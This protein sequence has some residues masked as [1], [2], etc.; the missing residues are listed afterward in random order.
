MRDLQRLAG[1]AALSD[2]LSVQREA[3]AAT[4]PR[5]QRQAVPALARSHLGYVSLRFGGIPVEADIFAEREV[6]P[7]GQV[8]GRFDGFA[9]EDEAARLARLHSNV[10][11][12][13]R[14][15][16]GKYHVFDT[17][18]PTLSG[19]ADGYAVMPSVAD[20]HQVVRWVNLVPGAPEKSWTR[21]VEQAQGLFR[22]YQV[23]RD[24]TVRSAAEEIFRELTEQGM[25]VGP[26]EVHVV[27][28][29]NPVPGKYNF[30]IDIGDEA[31][32]HGG[33]TGDVPTTLE[34]P[35][36]EPTLTLGPLAFDQRSPL[37]TYATVRH[38]LEHV[39]HATLA[40]EWVGKWRQAMEGRPS[41]EEFKPWLKTQLRR[42][43]IP[44]LDY[45]IVSEET[46]EA[47]GSANTECLGY[48][49]GFTASYHM[50]GADLDDLVLFKSITEIAQE[51]HGANHAVHA[52]VVSTLKGYVDDVMDD[53]HRARFRA[54]AGTKNASVPADAPAKTFYSALAK[55]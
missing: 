48:L 38:E 47:G 22:R 5:V 34:G 1:N 16:G 42:G 27:R 30:D 39:K 46:S 19:L 23:T 43:R 44:K 33:V 45:D 13:I 53:E 8:P 4:V 52:V 20:G 28:S 15:A 49:A 14:D 55:L 25:A 6:A 41:P 40:I 37:G 54:F 29:G 9:T 11:A 7:P 31:R 24:G 10:T 3:S 51:W 32:A 2:L 35:L 50:M 36:P 21:R 26:E 18:W 12:V 17:K